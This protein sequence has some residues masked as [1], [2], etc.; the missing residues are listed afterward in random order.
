MTCHSRHRSPS[1][2]GSSS[3]L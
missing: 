2:D 3:S 1:W